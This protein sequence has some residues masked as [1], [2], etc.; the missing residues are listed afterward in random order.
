MENFHD[1]IRNQAL[2]SSALIQRSAT[3][4]TTASPTATEKRYRCMTCGQSFSR[5]EHLKRHQTRH[6]G[7]KPFSCVFCSRNF[8]RKDRLQTHYNH[9]Q[10]RGERE[11]PNSIPKGRRPHACVTCISSKIRCDGSNPCSQCKKK[12]VPCRQK[13]SV[14]HESNGSNHSG[15]SLSLKNL[16]TVEDRVSIK[17][18][19]NGGT[20][21]F[22]EAFNLPPCDDRVRSLQ[23]HQQNEEEPEE[24]TDLASNVKSVDASPSS[25]DVD[26]SSMIESP[27]DHMDDQYLDF[28]TGPFAFIPSPGYSD[29][30][31]ELYDATKVMSGGDVLVHGPTPSS[32]ST[33]TQTHTAT[34]HDQVASTPAY[35][36]SVNMALYNKLWCLALDSKARQ[37]LTTCLNFLLTTDKI[38]KFISLYFRNWHLNSPLIHKPSFDPSKAPLNLVIA[39]VFVGAMYSRDQNE[40]LAA[41]KLVDLAE[42]VVFDSDIFALEMEITHA[43]TN[44]MHGAE[45]ADSTDRGWEKFQELQAG[46]LIVVAQYWAGSKIQKRRA[47]ECRF[48]DVIKVVRKLQV[49]RSR[50]QPSDR[51]SETAWLQK[52]SR[53]RTLA[54][55]ALLD[56]AMRI[57]SNYPCR[58]TL[59]ELDTDLP[60]KEAI[61]SSRHPFMQDESIFAP[62]LT[63]SQAFAMLFEGKAPTAASNTSSSLSLSSAL[64]RVGVDAAEDPSH[65]PTTTM[66]EDLNCDMT[67]FDLF[68]LIHY[69]YVYIH[70]CIMTLSMN[71]PTSS[72]PSRKLD[73]PLTLS[74]SPAFGDLKIALDRWRQIYQVVSSASSSKSMKTAGMFRNCFHFWLVAQLIIT[75]E[76]AVDVITGMEV[77]CD[78]ALTKLKVLFQ[79]E[80]ENDNDQE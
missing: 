22:T 64:V 75:K 79:N 51:I 11:P 66:A 44:H 76:E 69:L 38:S 68:I 53:I 7:A 72:L 52:E 6:T 59:A 71:L 77:N 63:I 15:V 19:L 21:T 46:F 17:A 31:L 25:I 32:D 70:S 34:S 42:L 9:C 62:R 43:M 36:S 74:S 45:T 12:K 55:I 10:R 26:Y 61:F 73:R 13:H 28:W 23:F 56:C 58:L 47:T 50:H 39:V 57:Y 5:A 78:D 1:L 16:N 3:A 49:H 35:V 2:L 41:K 27:L 54:V 8:S 20:D 24:A 40:R 14:Q 65:E 33:Q 4:K 30:Q 37:E 67:V 48:G 29:L 60:C 80:N 18:L